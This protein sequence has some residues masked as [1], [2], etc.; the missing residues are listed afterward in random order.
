VV[1]AVGVVLAGDVGEAC[2]VHARVRRG[3]GLEAT[4]LAMSI[5]VV[6]AVT[7]PGVGLEP[8]VLQLYLDCEIVCPASLQEP[9]RRVSQNAESLPWDSSRAIRYPAFTLPFRLPFGGSAPVQST[10]PSDAGSPEAT[11]WVNDRR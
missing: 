5:A 6:E 4:G 11:L 1:A 7:I 9:L 10:M 2:A 8:T 3:Q